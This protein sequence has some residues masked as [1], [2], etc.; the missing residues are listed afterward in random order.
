MRTPLI[1]GNWKMYKTPAEAA[2]F[3]RELREKLGEVKKAE[4][5]VCPPFVALYSVARELGGSIIGLGAQNMYCED[6]GAYTGEVAPPMLKEIGCSYVILGH[7]ERRQYFGESNQ[8]I[9]RKVRASLKAELTPIVCVGEILEERKNGITDQIIEKQLGGSLAGFSPLEL[10][11]IIV[12]YEPVWAIGTGLTAEAK[13]AQQVNGLIR[14]FLVQNAGP[15]IAQK[16]R[17]LYGGSVKPDNIAGLMAQPD[18][19][20]A[21]V[22]GASLKVNAFSEIVWNC[23]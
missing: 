14:S 5:V 6:E 22:G 17:V 2:N 16:I 23:Y 1:V 9:N 20:G 3:V 4:V 18:V 21:L 15:E 11:R 12:A 8:L 10:S 7:S 19:D 13:D